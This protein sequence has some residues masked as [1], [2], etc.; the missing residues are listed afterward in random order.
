MRAS[1]MARAALQGT[2]IE[3]EL[4]APRF[5]EAVTVEAANAAL[6]AHLSAE[7]VE[8]L[9]L[10]DPAHLEPLAARVGARFDEVSWIDAAEAPEAA[11]G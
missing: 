1:L 8:V 3:R 5:V 9:V 4:E 10:S 7:R 11:R 2:P 6:R